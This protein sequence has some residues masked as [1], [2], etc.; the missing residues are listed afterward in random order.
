V[1]ILTVDD[2]EFVTR[3]IKRTLGGLD[4]QVDT[5]N[6]VTQ[7][8][9]LFSNNEY[10]L[11]LTDLNMPDGDGLSV[12][13]QVKEAWPYTEVVVVSGH[14]TIARAVEA[15]KAGAFYFLEKPVDPDQLEILVQKALER[16]SLV[17]ESNNLRAQL[18]ERTQYLDI[19]G[20]S[21]PMQAIFETI[22]SIAKTDANVL[23]VGESGT[24]KELIANAIHYNSLRAKK[25]FIK[26]NCAALPR[27]LIESELFGHIKGAFTGAQGDK[28]GLITAAEGGS[29]LLDE[30][31]EMPIE[32]QPKLLRV[33]QD[34]RYRR[35]GS[36]REIEV[37]FR[38]ICSTNRTPSEAIESGHLREDLFYRINTVTVEV[39]PLRER[40]EDIQQ[41]GEHFLKRYAEKYDKPLMTLSSDVYER[42]FEYS[43]PGNVRELQNVIERAVLMTKGTT[44][45]LEHL[46]ITKAQTKE[47][48]QPK[49]KVEEY[50]NLTLDEVEREIVRR[51]LE[52]TGG[53]KQAAAQLLGIYRPRIYNLMKKHKIPDIGKE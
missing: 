49:V 35:I 5:A 42:M 2:D 46:A 32:V 10:D 6:S 47:E 52:R 20:S 31:G 40:Q 30:I 27:E 50:E 12:I 13:R 41:L 4:Y 25:P 15:T 33:L 37:D 26:V 8:G 28:R 7:A 23:I 45:T 24:G 16:R 34:R 39:P 22:E 3:A 17:A 44:L 11:V 19:V 48:P 43:W 53:N 1:R 51:A 18:K 9:E 29:L 14:G 38:L 21:K 36:D